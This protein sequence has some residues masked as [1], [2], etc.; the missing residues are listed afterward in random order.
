MPLPNLI[1]FAAA[2]FVLFITPGPGMATVVARTL[3]G[4]A[5]DAA[6]YAAGIFTGDIVILGGV[7]FGLAAFAAAAGPAFVAFKL[8][9][10]GYLVFLGISALAASRRDDQSAPVRPTATSLAG[11]WLAGFATPF[12]NPKPLLFY[13]AFVPA[14][15]DL[16]NVGPADF[17]VLAAV[18]VALSA[19]V[20]TIYIWGAKKLAGRLA[21]GRL[22]KYSQILV[23]VLFLGMAGLLAT[24]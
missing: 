24:G 17:A 8:I 19:A 4:G 10:A 14:F 18:M 16:S 1:A 11:G 5:A 21:S 15:F 6:V 13:G 9:A 12:S 20:S 23:G 22:R 3:H 7:V 2:V